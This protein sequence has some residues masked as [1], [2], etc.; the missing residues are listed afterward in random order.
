M[1]IKSN[2]GLPISKKIGVRTLCSVV[3]AIGLTMLYLMPKHFLFGS[4]SSVCV[5]HRMWNIDCPGCGV[6]RAL[7][8]FLH[9][10]VI[11]AC[12][13]NL[14]ILSIIP[15]CLAEIL[16]TL[17]FFPDKVTS[18]RRILFQSFPILLAA[19]YLIKYH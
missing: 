17:N 1:Q 4:Y 18:I 16:L 6:T 9:G 5:F 11:A 7:Y 15:I 14:A 13:L 8:S 10:D 12:K 19:N 2:I 3:M